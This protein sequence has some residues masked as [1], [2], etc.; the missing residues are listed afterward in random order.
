LLRKTVPLD[1]LSLGYRNQKCIDFSAVVIQIMS[2]RHADKV[3][4]SWLQGDVREMG[5]I[6]DE[7]VDV[8]FDKGTLD[9]MISGS[10]WDPP[11]Q[12]KTNVKRYIDEV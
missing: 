6:A 9:S 10:P 11:E 2:E 7:T 8:A 5:Q 3:G 12:V 1:L 4:I